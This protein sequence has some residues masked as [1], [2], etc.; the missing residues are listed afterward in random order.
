MQLL[1]SFK[2]DYDRLDP[3][4]Q[5]DVDDCLRDLGREFIP[6]VRRWHCVNRPNRP[7]IF[8]ADVYPNKSY[9]VSCHVQDDQSGQILVLRR[10]RRH[11]DIDRN[12]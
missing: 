4:Q 5:A 2:Q 10:V 6:A 7:S 11:K 1:E 12:P 3:Q 8:T 9:K